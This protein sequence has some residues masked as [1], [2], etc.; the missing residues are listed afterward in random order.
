MK[1]LWTSVTKGLLT[2]VL[3]AGVGIVAGPLSAAPADLMSGDTSHSGVILYA[4]SKT[5]GKPPFQNTQQNKGQLEKA[6]FA[7]LEEKSGEA[8]DENKSLYHGVQGKHPPYRR[9]W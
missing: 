3:A 1:R 4:W 9:N 8:M 2:S 6:Q 5:G 7:R